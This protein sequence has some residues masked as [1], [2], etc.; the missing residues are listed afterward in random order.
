MSNIHGLFSKK[1]D[2]NDDNEKD[3]DDSNNRYVGG[4]GDR[5]GGSG[6]AVQPN[7][8][9]ENNGGG[10]TDQDAIFGLAE[11]AG[12]AGGGD[13][14]QGPPRRTITM[15][16][17]GFVV[18]DGPYR[19]L[20]DPEN[21]DF[22]RSLAMGRTPRELLQ[23]SEEDGSGSNPNVT[24]GLID[25]RT[26][27]Y[28]ETFQSFSGTGN[29]LGTTTATTDATSTD[30]ILDPSSFSDTST[31]VVDSTLPTTSIQVRL[32]NGKRQVF[33][34]NLNQTVLQLG[35]M[36]VAS[37]STDGGSTPFVLTSGFPPRPITNLSQSIEEAGLKGA[38][39]IQKKAA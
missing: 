28:E 22:L 1:D 38:Q 3:Q 36:I 5:G 18:D 6:L 17:S 14:G 21:A 33:K 37:T 9:D 30:G 27:E 20:D 29:S 16:Q 26:Q 11:Q 35:Q 15:Y 12:A 34:I 23:Q 7:N 10:G 39:V 31:P 13:D 24:V 8:N 2:D 25:K 19:R 4:I 32:M